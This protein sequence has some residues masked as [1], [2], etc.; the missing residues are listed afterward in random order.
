MYT[1][2][3]TSVTELTELPAEVQDPQ[4]QRAFL[5]DIAVAVPLDFPDRPSYGPAQNCVSA[6]QLTDQPNVRVRLRPVPAFDTA[7]QGKLNSIVRHKV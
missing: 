3:D 1:Q 5:P 7:G 2:T 4:V 6:V